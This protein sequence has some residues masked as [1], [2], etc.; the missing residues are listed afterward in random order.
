[1][2]KKITKWLNS[3][4]NIL[5]L[6]I[7]VA[8]IVLSYVVYNIL[9][10]MYEGDTYFLIDTGREIIK[11]GDVI[12]ENIWSCVPGM[13][14]VAQQW[15]YCVI[16]AF[17]Q[18]T[19]GAV[20]MLIFVF[21]QVITYYFLMTHLMKK[22]GLNSQFRY[23]LSIVVMFLGQNYLF[24]SRPETITIILFILLAICLEKYKETDKWY[25]LLGIPALNILEVNFHSSMWLFHY[26]II[27]AYLVPAF[28]WPWKN[29]ESKNIKRVPVIVV[30]LLSLSVLLVNPYGLD[31]VLYII[32]AYMSNAF[33]FVSIE[34][35][36]PTQI[37]SNYG[38]CAFIG[39]FV[40]VVVSKLKSC[41]STSINITFGF[42]LLMAM[43]IRNN[44]FILFSLIYPLADLGVAFLGINTKFNW[45]KYLNMKICLLLIAV[46]IFTISFTYCEFKNINNIEGGVENSAMFA[47]NMNTI[48]DYLDKHADENNKI[49]TGFNVG[50]YMEYRGYRNLFIDARPECYMKNITGNES[51]LAEYYTYCSKGKKNNKKEGESSI[52]NQDE[53]DDWFA[54]YNFD[55]IIVEAGTGSFLAGYMYSNPNYVLAPGSES[56][57]GEPWLLFE[58]VDKVE[59]A[60]EVK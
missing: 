43:F 53:V 44:M 50:A 58:R 28:Y 38:F 10:G 24:C 31:G 34:E 12:R 27:L 16:I 33:S 56:E 45:H 17:A 9:H 19:F 3:P 49:L 20:G 4:A 48:A 29:K 22:L 37:M 32:N 41:K 54:K 25:W 2:S 47:N 39:I 13:K 57:I 11:N 30:S 8:V 59:K 15:L 35:M 46:N 52:L 23:L 18:D 26:A 7:L 60:V 40:L 21:I 36:L 1:M 55:Y 14:F 51:P 5:F 42:S 6:K